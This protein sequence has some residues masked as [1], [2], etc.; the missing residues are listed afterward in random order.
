[1]SGEALLFSVGE[2]LKSGQELT[3]EEKVK[4]CERWQ[5]SGLSKVMY[6][7]RNK[8]VFSTFC[9]WC[10]RFLP[11]MRTGQLCQV[12]VI[13]AVSKKNMEPP[14]TIEVSLPNKI[15]A[16]VSLHEHQV[17]NLIKGLVYAASTPR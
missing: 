1:M 10:S 8:L 13:E 15:S 2:E 12:A 5:R 11:K 4:I 6:C 17:F 3:R 9:G 7:K 16:K 14:I